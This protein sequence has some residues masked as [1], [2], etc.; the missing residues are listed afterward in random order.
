M[1]MWALS[2][3]EKPCLKNL[4]EEIWDYFHKDIQMKRKKRNSKQ[5]LGE[6]IGKPSL[7]QA[8]S[9]YELEAY[10]TA[11]KWAGV[12]F[13]STL[14]EKCKKYHINRKFYQGSCKVHKPNSEIIEELCN[15]LGKKPEKLKRVLQ[16]RNLSAHESYNFSKE[17]V[18]FMITTIEEFQKW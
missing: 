3:T 10:D 4:R 8:K 15:R 13:L 5:L 17:D 14:K 2:M 18:D 11:T 9:Y 1:F 6:I 7:M 16:L 12:A